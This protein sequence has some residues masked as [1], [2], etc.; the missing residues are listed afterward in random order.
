MESLSCSLNEAVTMGMGILFI[1]Y[2]FVYKLKREEKKMKLP[3]GP[4]P[5][6]VIG[7]LHLLGNLPHQAFATLAKKYGSLMFLRLGSIPT[8]VVSSP[9]MAKEFLKTHDLVFATRPY[10]YKGKNI[11]YGHNDVAFGLYGESWRQK[12]KLMTVELLT[13]KRNDSFRFVRE[14]EVS[15]MI[16]SIWQEREHGEQCVDVKRR[17]SSLT[18][19]IVCRMLA[20]RTYSD[21][22]LNGGHGFKEMVE[23]MFAVF[24]AFP[25]GEYIPS[26]DW[27]DLQGF[28]RRMKAVHQIFDRF[29]EK[30]I[31]EH[32]VERKARE[33]DRVKDMVDVMLSMAETEGQAMSRVDIK[34]VILD[35]VNAGMETPV[36]LLDWA[37]SEL[38]KNPATLARVQQEIESVV[39][40]DRRVK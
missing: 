17:L 28:R 12:R 40:R 19:N 26:L 25:I 30:V 36:T 10:S 8:I 2:C 7:S 33:G 14:E 32:I 27:M 11:C 34:A 29:A 39:G 37:I 9:A 16:A 20:G 18:Q 1:F 21:N 38:L 35:F 5:W 3:P 4:R 22:E 15:S 24:G 31:D 23:E 6:P 13:V